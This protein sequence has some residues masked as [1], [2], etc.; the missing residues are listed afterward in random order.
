MRILGHFV[1]D[2]QWYR[3]IAEAELYQELD[4]IKRMKQ[5][6]LEENVLPEKDMTEMEAQAA[7]VVERSIAYASNECTEPSIDTLY[8]DIYANGEVI[9]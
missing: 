7:K 8:E 1:A 4:P 3:D 5:Y 9:K 2:D 6:F